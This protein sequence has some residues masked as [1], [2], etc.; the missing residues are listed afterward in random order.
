MFW[1]F[2]GYS[3]TS[4][5]DTLLDKPDVR[6]EDLLDESD[7]IQELKSHHTK[8]I[9]HL[10]DENNL[11]A[12]LR[13]V[14]AP[15]PS[16]DS[17]E[18]SENVKET[19]STSGDDEADK[20]PDE[21]QEKAE[22]KRLKY[23]YVACEILSCETW[24]ITESL[25]ASTEFLVEFW[26]FLRRPAPLDP[27][28][29]GY[30]TK[31]NETLF[32]KKTE[33]MVEFF[34][35]LPG[36]VPAMLQHVD[37]PMVMDLLLK[38]IS[39]EKSDGGAGIVDW[40]HDQDLIPMLLSSLSPECNSSTQTSAGDFLK[41]IITISAN[42]ALNEQSCI[43][44][45]SLTRQLV[46]EKCIRQL[47][48]YMLKG[49]NPL[50][51]GVGIVIE[52]IRKNNSDYDPEHG[53][54]P[55]SPPTNHDP[56]YLG[57]LLRL[58]AEN[59]PAFMNLI[60][61]SKHT[62]TQGDTT[63][64]VERGQ[65]KSAWGTQIEPLGFD[66]FKT[67]E[68]M[69]ELLHC[70]NMGLLNER[71]SEEFIKERDAERERLRSQGAFLSNK[72][73]EDSA[74]DISVTSSRFDTAFTPSA[75]TSTEE[76]RIANL[77][78]EDGFEKVA[79]SDATETST[80]SD[81]DLVDEPL[82]PRESRAT[83]N[84]QESGTSPG[85]LDDTV[86][87]LS[88]EN[89]DDTDMTS[90]PN[91]PDTTTH[92]SSQGNNE[93][94]PSSHPEDKPAPLFASSSDPNRT[95]TA[96]SPEPT[97][98]PDAPGDTSEVHGENSQAE[99][100]SIQ[101]SRDQT[102]QV[103]DHDTSTAGEA[104]VVGDYLKIQFVENKVVP[105][106]LSFFFRFPWN[107]FL[108]N[109]VYDVVQQVFNGPMDRGYNR[110]LAFDLFESGR[111][112]DAIIEGQRRSDEAQ[113]AKNMRLGYMGHLTLVA[114]EVV[115]F[116]ERHPR[117]LLSPVVQDCI[118]SQAWEEYVTKVLAE[119]RERDNAIL[120][121]FRPDNGLG[122]RQAVLNAVNSGQGFGS[123]SGLAAAGLNGGQAQHGLDSIDLSNNGSATS[124]G[125]NSSGSL[126]S[127]FG[128]SS[129]DDD[130]DMDDADDDE[131]G[132]SETQTSTTNTGVSSENS[133][134]PVPL[135]PPP[136]APLNV[137]PSRARR[138]L[139]DRLAR[140]KQEAEQEAA[141]SEFGSEADDP[142]A[143]L[144]NGDEQDSADPF[145]LDEEEQ[146]ITNFGRR[147]NANTGGFGDTT[148][149]HHSFT[150]SRGLTSLFSSA[151]DDTH[152]RTIRDDFDG[153]LDDSSSE[154]SGSDIE[155]ENPPLEARTSLERR[156]LEV[157]EDEEM[158]EMV[159]PTQEDESNS[160]DEEVLSPM[161]KEKLG[162]AFGMGDTDEQAS[163][164]A[165]QADHDDDDDDDDDSDQLVEIAMPASM[166]RRSK[167]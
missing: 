165:G 115:K 28:Q 35:S 121:G 63:V 79:V 101:S 100:D 70:S 27:L 126:S 155:P 33:E 148:R 59:V 114:E 131:R 91:E 2:G 57:N 142:F 6:L 143:A 47:I 5:I 122:P 133:D 109:V 73:S 160:S 98:G 8:L 32:E 34:K 71:G 12:L 137:E 29:A 44:P 69:A 107:N 118:Y 103:T 55:D 19:E 108:H 141:A 58:F 153:S 87:R 53:H 146:D 30:F 43:G 130:E 117:E 68:L 60:L 113:Q 140:H 21:E 105:T 67:C 48:S 31:V 119:T 51:V 167:G 97:G 90:P 144:D 4:T 37:C 66:R 76:L 134:Q 120:G 128:S 116:G 102:M 85:N 81:Q 111:I 26:D 163:E 3:N 99:G 129:D 94:Q 17:G 54:S 157:F 84:P 46:S 125:Y 13:Y 41:A 38:I 15:G 93:D 23:A 166:K 147:S 92:F 123:S 1:R 22:K 42:A 18:S 89:V 14:I 159:A 152:G 112:T 25:M 95:P 36:I 156:P 158:G 83:Q 151:N 145:S 96:H 110:Y 49:G 161:E 132:R 45:N 40:L 149:D 11:H 154:G 82:S 56:I 162:G 136:P 64:V 127:G 50:T 124:A 7:L 104:P 88:L 9:E 164:F 74:V 139:A 16:S 80:K 86:R 72:Q 75:S 24:S 10:R 61:S 62:V 20:P 65:L 138:R 106:I 150:V 77:N 52:V 39:L 135:L 78:D